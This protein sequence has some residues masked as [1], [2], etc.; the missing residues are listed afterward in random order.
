MFESLGFQSLTA[1]E[2]AIWFGL[3]L[4]LAFGAMAQISRFCLRRGLVV[5]PDRRAALGVW[6]LALAVALL[7]TQAAVA[8]GFAS[9]DGHR[10]L[11]GDLPVVAVLLGG[12]MFGAGMVL[13]RGCLS[14][15]TV[16][17]ASGNLRA[18]TVLLVFAVVAHAALKGV[19]A[20]VRVG[21]GSVT[22]PLGEAASLA[23]LPGGTLFWTGLLA[24]SALTLVWR[25]GA[26]LRDL[27]FGVGIGLLVPL[28]WV[29]TG[30]VL[31]D[32]FDPIA[33]QSLSFTLP[34]AETLFWGVASTAIAPTFGVG[35]LGGTA[36]GAAMAAILS[37]AFRW[38]SFESPAQ[39]GRYS[40]GAVLMGFGG[41]LAG[42]C[43]LGAGLSG[44]ATLGV[45]ALLALGAIA[46]G[47][48]ATDAA[49]R[50]SDERQATQSSAPIAAE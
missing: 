5:G 17:G 12:L 2:A 30:Y 14:R 31:Y 34:A 45:S 46:L 16:L 35:L 10:F 29:G 40:A 44:V 3:V 15:L 21:L 50:R 4:G 28:G 41:V 38:E 1:P 6:A 25:S 32:D 8:M 36:A 26:P 47:A 43:T 20:P 48:M 49:L 19:L 37:G 7:G 11:A 33:L 39:T 22:V 18:L 13:T 42:G 27:G 23:A 9:F 24:V